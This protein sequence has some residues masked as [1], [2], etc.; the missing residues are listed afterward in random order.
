[1]AFRSD[2][3]HVANH[4]GK[5]LI[6]NQSNVKRLKSE[7]HTIKQHQ[8][9]FLEEAKVNYHQYQTIDAET[10][11]IMK[12]I[13]KIWLE[14]NSKED[15][16]SRSDGSASRSVG[17][18]SCSS[19]Q[20]DE[21]EDSY[22]LT[23]GGTVVLKAEDDLTSYLNS[24]CGS[25]SPKLDTSR[26][27]LADPFERLL[28][29]NEMLA[30]E[31]KAKKRTIKLL[32]RK[33]MNDDSLHACEGQE[34]PLPCKNVMNSNTRLKREIRLLMARLDDKVR[35]NRSLVR[36]LERRNKSADNDDISR[37]EE[38]NR[39]LEMRLCSSLK[40]R[41]SLETEIQRGYITIKKQEEEAT[42]LKKK[43]RELELM[44]LKPRIIPKG[45]ASTPP[46]AVSSTGDDSIL[47]MRRT[48]SLQGTPKSQKGTECA[49]KTPP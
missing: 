21:I 38:N 24:R 15:L 2:Y 13:R 42:R 3:R 6:E 32:S 47:I 34:S 48:S 37:L 9:D 11:S 30:D 1:M 14:I 49:K 33:L 36:K 8:G 5:Q 22:D 41:S 18:S 40:H 20:D 12:S 7:V 19:N 25:R 16:T 35:E 29:E 45:R 4:L 43:I 44:D 10:K 39:H 31:L 28:R 46:P 26:D 27:S 23:T 17:D